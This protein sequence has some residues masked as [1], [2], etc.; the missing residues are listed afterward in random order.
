MSTSES[1]TI[2]FNV[3]STDYSIPLGM[4]VSLDGVVFYENA[5]VSS[6]TPVQHQ[7]SD[8]DGEHELVFELF[9]KRP[10]HTQ[11]DQDNNIVSDAMLSVA[12]IEIDEIDIDQITQFQ[13]IYHHDCN[14][15]QAPQEDRFYGDMGCNGTVQLKFSTPVYLWL[16][17]NM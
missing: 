14:G 4:R 5:H 11:I 3:T 17:E 9:G 6:E 1:V 12:G 7:L 16:L 10:E 2:K 13:A 15:T 8:D